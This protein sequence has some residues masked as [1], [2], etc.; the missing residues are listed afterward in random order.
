MGSGRSLGFFKT[1]NYKY[2]EY[3][4]VNFARFCNSMVLRLFA[5]SIGHICDTVSEVVEHF[6]ETASKPLT[7]FA[8]KLHCS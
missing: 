1:R 6:W 2:F 8:K 4:K 3:K 5:K 7:T